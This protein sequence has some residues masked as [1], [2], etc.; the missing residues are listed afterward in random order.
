MFPKNIPKGFISN[1]ENNKIKI[2]FSWDKVSCFAFFSSFEQINYTPTIF[3]Y[4][5]MNPGGGKESRE[6]G[7]EGLK[8]MCGQ[9]PKAFRP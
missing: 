7:W 9:A 8:W 5:S 4:Y 2:G 1:E 3:F 6:D